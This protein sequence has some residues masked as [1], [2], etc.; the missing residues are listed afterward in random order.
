[1]EALAILMLHTTKIFSLRRTWRHQ[2]RKVVKPNRPG[3]IL[4][5]THMVINN[6][7]KCLSMVFDLHCPFSYQPFVH[8]LHH[9]GGR[10][11]RIPS[12]PEGEGDNPLQYLAFL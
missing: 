7:E 3:N 12:N 1:M 10:G 11:G 9:E 2:W 6:Y 4:I 8:W 5:V